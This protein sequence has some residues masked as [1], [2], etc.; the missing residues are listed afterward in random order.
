MCGIAAMLGR[1]S[2]SVTRRMTDMLQ[3]RGPDGS[4]IW[5]DDDCALGHS[6]LAIVDVAGS[7]Q[8][9]H[10]D[11]GCVAVVN[12]EIYNHEEIRKNLLSYP[13]KTRGDSESVLALHHSFKDWVSRLDG[14]F[15]ICLW[16][17]ENK[18]LTLARDPLGVKP[19]IRTLVDGSLLVAS[20]AKVF[21][22]HEE[23]F[24]KIN[25]EAMKT[26]IAFEYRLGDATLFED[27]EQ[28][29]P[30]TYEV[31]GLEG[32]KAVLRKRVKY[33]EYSIEQNET[34]DA[35]T[36]LASLTE[37][38]ADRLMSDVPVGVV[39]S[40]GLDSA[41]VA[42]LAERAAH[43]AGQ[44]IPECWTVAEDEEN[45][46][47]K[48]AELVAESL[49]LVHHQRILDENSLDKA[50]PRMS[51]HGEDLDVTE[52]FFQP[53]FE[54]MSKDVTVG[55]CGQGAD[56]LHAGYPRYRELDAHREL[57]RSR[58]AAMDMQRDLSMFDDLQK[59]LQF[60]LD[61]GQLSNFQLRLVDRHSM[62]HGLEIRVPFL[63][64]AHLKTALALPMN[65]RL[66][67]SA[68]WGDEKKA[69]RSAAAL[70]ALPKEVVKRPKMPAGRATAPKM[71]DRFLAEM[72][73]RILELSARYENLERGLKGQ[74]HTTLGLGLFESMHII[75]RG[76]GR[77]NM[78]V[79]GLL[80]D[81]L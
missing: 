2:A 7:N 19:L 14:I 69:L 44:P 62:A 1:P 53:L 25:M 74:A 75:D 21:R 33:A 6:R 45:P 34:W 78:S 32:E 66:P 48:A 51:W 73:P 68:R 65:E 29:S 16:D 49:G 17:P 13:W 72:K 41:L 76:I 42:G 18:E 10:S 64:S 11:H 22:S 20:E 8:P 58:L 39:L 80:D 57:I 63:G 79:E 15:A 60:E 77:Q 43:I 26:R 59:T 50:V 52:M 46:D 28:V 70:T 47:W 56:E 23:Y 36:L 3:H 9:L 35:G 38:L 67:I 71:L 37:S 5:K 12:G 81:L 30:G 31:W 54:T 61:D 4:G 55:L 24:P 27:V 40:G